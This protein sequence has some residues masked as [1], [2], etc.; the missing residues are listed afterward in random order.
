MGLLGFYC[1]AL[2][3]SLLP[4]FVVLLVCVLRGLFVLGCLFV[5]TVGLCCV[6]CSW[7]CVFSF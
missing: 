2:F 1:F 6:E 7:L 4:R 3:V 5:S